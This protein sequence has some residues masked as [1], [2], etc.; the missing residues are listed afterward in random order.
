[1]FTTWISFFGNPLA[2]L[3]RLTIH[4]RLWGC[5]GDWR[6]RR[7]FFPVSFCWQDGWTDKILGVEKLQFFTKEKGWFFMCKHIVFTCLCAS[8]LSFPQSSLCFWTPFSFHLAFSVF[9]LLL[10]F[11][12]ESAK[13]I[14]NRQSIR[15]SNKKIELCSLCLKKIN[16]Q[17]SKSPVPVCCK[18]SFLFVR[19][20]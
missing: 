12:T 11:W 15:S 17:A 5:S 4:S 20:L 9:D 6:G 13:S 7:I 8:T 19:C 3:H 14:K 16:K 2:P 10:V 18:S 1:M